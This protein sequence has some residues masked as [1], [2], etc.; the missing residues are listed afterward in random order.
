MSLIRTYS[1]RAKPDNL[2]GESAADAIIPVTLREP[3]DI[4]DNSQCAGSRRH[5]KI[6]D[7][8][9]RQIAETYSRLKT[10]V[11]PLAVSLKR[12]KVQ[13][14]LDFGQ[15]GLSGINCSVCGLTYDP[16]FA[17]DVD[18]HQKTHARF[19]NQE[20]IHPVLPI[21]TWRR[22]YPSGHQI[23]ECP[24]E[25][26]SSQTLEF[27]RRTNAEYISPLDLIGERLMIMFYALDTSVIAS[28]AIYR[29]VENHQTNRVL[30]ERI[31]T[32]SGHRR[33]GFA[34]RLLCH[35]R[36]CGCL[37][38]DHVQCRDACFFE[39]SEISFSQPTA[40]GKLLAN[41]ISCVNIHI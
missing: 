35:L 31:W 12:R 36:R 1:R 18:L 16:S 19:L 15:K 32:H 41:S 20:K 13:S 25:R 8:F 33:K 17:E 4:F 21:G 29:I 30:L 28:F 2:E 3:E 22:L 39:P 38:A 6:T 34:S 24:L 26:L 11:K 7:F 10:E 14:Y 27:V 23:I 5:T 37:H 9:P 40:L